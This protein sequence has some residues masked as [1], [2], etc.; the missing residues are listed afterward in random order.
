MLCRSW[1]VGISLLTINIIYCTIGRYSSLFFN[2][3]IIMENIKA[4]FK[5]QALT[6]D[7]QKISYFVILFVFAAIMPAFIHIQWITWP[8]VNASLFLATVL[9]WPLHAALLWLAPSSVALS[10]WLLPLPLAPMVPFIMISNVLLVW[11]FIYFKKINFWIWVLLWSIAKFIF[12]QLFVF[13]LSWIL[14]N[15]KLFPKV[16]M[17]M[18][19]PQLVTAIVWWIIAYVILKILWKVDE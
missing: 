5:L 11:S 10:W 2:N 3:G 9:V 19:W 13:L 1:V 6:I 8:M 14:L 12:L 18:S 7:Y 4:S 17:M 15:E 16:A